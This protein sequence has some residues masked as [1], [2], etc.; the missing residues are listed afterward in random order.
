MRRWKG[1]LGLLFV[2]TPLLAQ[3]IPPALRDWQGW[4]LHDTPQHACP[5]LA[6]SNPDADSYQCIW[7]GRL[8]LDA[9]KSG[10]HFSLDVHVD[11]AGWTDLP[12]DDHSWPQQV[13]VNNKAWPVLNHDDHPAVRLEPGDYTVQG[14]LPWDTR[15]ARLGVPSSIGLVE[16]SLDGNAVGRIER[17]DDQLTLGEAAAAQRQAD[18]LAV[19]V[20]RHLTD[21][22]P[23]M[24]DTQLQLNVTGSAREQLLGPALP[25]GFIATALD[26]DLPAQ[27]ENDGRL[28]LQLR[29]GQWVVHLSARG[30]E[31]LH[32]V[33]LTV[34]ADPWP[35]QEVWSYSDDPSLRSTRVDGRG[36]DAAQA[37]VPP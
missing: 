29:P 27:L 15:P 10:G 1:M 36:T 22:M 30:T 18:T 20:Y 17:H 23:A 25:K 2:V 8:A 28:R 32:E 14:N 31:T 19:R 35:K 13:T 7:P 5:F 11:A 4:V 33:R 24:L 12:G 37:G 3:D 6:N 26:S 16:L 9:G 34:P 21:G